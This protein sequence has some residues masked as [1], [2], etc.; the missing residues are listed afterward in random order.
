MKQDIPDS[1]LRGDYVFLGTSWHCWVSL[2]M[3]VSLSALLHLGP[4]FIPR[5]GVKP[6]T[7]VSSTFSHAREESLRCLKDTN[8]SKDERNQTTTLTTLKMSQALKHKGTEA[9]PSNTL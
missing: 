2:L 5:K 3:T 1:P 8:S 7:A 4:N 9:I 6:E